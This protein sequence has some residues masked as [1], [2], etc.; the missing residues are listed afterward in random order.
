MRDPEGNK[1]THNF[2]PIQ[3]L[4]NRIVLANS[5]HADEPG[6]APIFIDYPP[7]P[8]RTTTQGSNIMDLTSAEQETT[9]HYEVTDWS[10]TIKFVPAPV[11]PMITRETTTLGKVTFPDQV[12]DAP[13]GEE[14]AATHKTHRLDRI[15]GKGS[16]QAAV[17]L[18]PLLSLIATAS[19]VI[20][21]NL[22][23]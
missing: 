11:Q 13:A 1:L 10:T 6:Y 9:I 3:P 17:K 12:T 18:L 22:L 7:E 15:R 19:L 8:D 16:G 23:L 14:V 21:T 4:N 5:Q 2:R 20:A